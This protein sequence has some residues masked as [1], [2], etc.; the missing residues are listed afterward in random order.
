MVVA[1]VLCRSQGRW[2]GSHMLSMLGDLL[3]LLTAFKTRSP[4]TT[5]CM[6]TNSKTTLLTALCYRMT[7]C[8]NSGLCLLIYATSYATVLQHGPLFTAVCQLMPQCYNTGLSLFTD[9]CYLMPQCCN[10][11]LCSLLYVIFRLSTTT[12]FKYLC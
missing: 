11:G 2:N 5:G 3:A 4:R 12:L 6:P 7:Q 8:Y 1:R 10:T 9:A